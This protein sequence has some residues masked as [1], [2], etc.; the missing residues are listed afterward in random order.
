M[1]HEPKKKH[2]KAYKRTRR[3][4][5]KLAALKLIICKNCH[6]KTLAHMD[7]RSCGFYAG[8]PTRQSKAQVKVTRV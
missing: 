3:A 6:Q 7:C 5:I 1:P 4:S 2:A 8:K